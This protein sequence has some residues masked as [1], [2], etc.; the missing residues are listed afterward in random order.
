MRLVG[1]IIR[2]YHDARSSECQNCIPAVG[3]L[4]VS[5]LNMQTTDQLQYGAITQCEATHIVHFVFIRG[6]TPDGQERL[7]SHQMGKKG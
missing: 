2:M 3:Y 6:V 5:A 4:P 7:G 1:F